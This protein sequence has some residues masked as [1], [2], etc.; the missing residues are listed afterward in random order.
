[1]P[2]MS[3]VSAER[4]PV[5]SGRVRVRVMSASLSFS[6]IMLSALAPATT[7][8]VPNTAATV[9]TQSSAPGAATAPKNVV[10][11]TRRVIFG[12]LSSTS[13]PI[14]AG[15]PTGRW[16]AGSRAG[17]QAKGA[18]KGAA[19][20]SGTVTPEISEPAATMSGLFLL[21]VDDLGVGRGGRHRGRLVVVSQALLEVLDALAQALANIAQLAAPK[22]HQD[23]E[24][25]EQPV[26]D[27]H[28]ANQLPCRVRASKATTLRGRP[29]DH[30]G[31]SP[32]GQGRAILFCRWL[33]RSTGFRAAIPT[34]CTRLLPGRNCSA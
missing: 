16:S 18:A 21:L 7:S 2:N 5:G 14:R 32:P 20:V 9:T 34:T 15:V 3:A 22:E 17:A 30:H 13:A 25:D 1:M 8:A 12:L 6:S 33:L 10:N 27:R 11:T 19:A 29:G 31:F 28:G 24:G 23:D 26:T 4:R